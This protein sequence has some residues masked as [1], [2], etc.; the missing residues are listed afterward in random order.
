LY[1]NFFQYRGP[2]I[3]T[4][5]VC[6]FETE[7]SFNY[8][9]SI[10]YIWK[11]RRIYKVAITPM[12]IENLSQEEGI[13]P[14]RIVKKYRRL[15][16]KRIRK[17]SWKRKQQK[18]SNCFGLGHNKRYCTNQPGRKNRRGERARDWA[19]DSSLSSRSI[20]L[21]STIS[22][23]SSLS[24]SV[25]RM[26]NALSSEEAEE[27]DSQANST[28]SGLSELFQ[29]LSKSTSDNGGAAATGMKRRRPGA[30]A[31]PAREM[32]ARQ[33]RKPARYQAEE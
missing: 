13:Q 17:N 25:V 1:N 10:Y 23:P 6:R 9:E 4:I 28:D 3:Y 24:S 32:P 2:C 8:F 21:L 26:L 12:S 16:T 7:D 14:P 30:I 27:E 18:Y 31:E 5:T 29:N 11:F 33:R 15:Q 19:L 22:T 20:L